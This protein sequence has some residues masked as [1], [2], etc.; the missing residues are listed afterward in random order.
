M[1][2]VVAL[3]HFFWYA[4]NK[5]VSLDNIAVYS[6]LIRADHPMMHEVLE[7]RIDSLKKKA[8]RAI[9]TCFRMVR[10]WLLRHLIITPTTDIQRQYHTLSIQHQE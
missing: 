3:S 1:G 6:V 9:R 8:S 7:T 5:F 4:V 2:I 10:Y